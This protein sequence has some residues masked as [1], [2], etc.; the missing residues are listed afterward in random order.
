VAPS[1]ATE[2]TAIWAVI[3]NDPFVAPGSGN[4][5]VV[6]MVRLQGPFAASPCPSGFLG[7]LPSA[8]D[9]A[10]LDDQSGLIVVIDYFSGA[11]IGWLH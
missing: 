4:A 6:W 8:D 7:R 3:G 5:R 10:C 11:L 1:A 2:P 9:P